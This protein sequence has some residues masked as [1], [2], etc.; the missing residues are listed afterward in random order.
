MFKFLKK[1]IA[2]KIN[3]KASH[4]PS[5]V[6]NYMPRYTSIKHGLTYKVS[7][8]EIQYLYFYTTYTNTFQVFQLKKG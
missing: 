1:F 2:Q 5:K 6:V 4:P 3:A 7:H 8:Q